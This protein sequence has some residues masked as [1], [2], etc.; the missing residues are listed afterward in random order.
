MPERAPLSKRAIEEL[1][2]PLGKTRV[3]LY[4]TVAPA[5][6]V[7]K[8][9]TG[10]TSFY[11]YR[12]VC[13]RPQRMRLGSVDDL[14]VEQARKMAAAKN[15]AIANGDDPMQAKRVAR[16]EP[17]ARELWADFLE[18][19]LKPH[20]RGVE[21]AERIW[22]SYCGS[23]RARRLSTITQQSI[24]ELH[25]KVGRE[26]GRTQANR[27]LA[28]VRSMFA[29]AVEWQKMDRN[30]ALGV[31]AF[32]EV[33]RERRLTA[34][35]MPRFLAAVDAY[36]DETMRDLFRMLLFTGQRKGNVVAMRWAHINLADARWT[37]PA[38]ETKT[39]KVYAVPLVA[40]AVEIL[41]RRRAIVAGEWVFPGRGATG[42]ITEPKD[43]W[44]VITTAAGIADL[45]IHDLR[46]T[47][48]SWMADL[49]ASLPTIGKMLG[50][51]NQSTTAIYSRLSDDPVRLAAG[52]AAAAMLE[53]VEEK[54]RAVIDKQLPV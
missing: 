25:A 27:V 16:E 32:P 12:R 51:R 28:L 34:D 44:R 26:N 38:G 35:E 17:T 3:Q 4:D 43:A 21:E 36:P 29:R 31:T 13:G 23:L 11:L 8:T 2:V 5:L 15:L 47:L 6:L 49:N 10:S 22:D 41:E 39:G 53:T 50:H 54:P 7:E 33:E 1:T 20:T 37:I 48:G 45:R 46:R 30:P 9:I 24:A 14:T 42:H 40:P 19:H 52:R 18:L